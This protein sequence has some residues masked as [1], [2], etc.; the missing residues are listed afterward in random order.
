MIERA[1]ILET[2]GEIQPNS[3]PDFHLETQ[4]R[5]TGGTVFQPNAHNLPASSPRTSDPQTAKKEAAALAIL[6]LWNTKLGELWKNKTNAIT[7]DHK[8]NKVTVTTDELGTAL[9]KS[10]AAVRQDFARYNREM[11]TAVKANPIEFGNLRRLDSWKQ[12]FGDWL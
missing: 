3:L 7:D 8:K 4:L 10:G 11:R 1:L 2:T 12:W 6:Q 9:A 5:N